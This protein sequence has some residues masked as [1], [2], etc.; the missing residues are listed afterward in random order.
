VDTVLIDPHIIRQTIPPSFF[1]MNVSAFWD[2]A[3]GSVAS[4]R[5]LRQ[6]PITTIRFP[7]GAP[8][9]WYDWQQPTYKGRSHTSPQQIWQYTHSFGGDRVI[10]STNYQGHLPNPPGQSYAVNSPENAAAWVAYN[11]RH[12]IR[13]ALEVGNEEDISLLHKADDRAYLAY[14]NAFNRQARAMHRANPNVQVL[15]PVGTNEWYWWGLD[16][17]GM[18]L[19]GAGN[20]TGTGQVD[21]VSL[22]FYKGTS[23]LD[24]RDVAQYWLSS[25]GPWSAI[26]SAIHAHDTRNLPVSITEWNVGTPALNT[27]FNRTFGHA[28]V[29]ADMIGALA[30]S[31]V[32]QED[33]FDI[34]GAAAWGLLYGVGESRPVDTPTPTYYA[35][36]LWKHMGNQ[37]LDLKQ[38]DDAGSVM[39]AYATRAKNGPIQVLAI[40]KQPAART[41][42]IELQGVS[43]Q[44]QRVSVYSLRGGTSGISSL[45]SVYDGKRT[46]S[47]LRPLPG[48]T[49]LGTARG[50]VISYT[51]P[52]YTAV[53]LNVAGVTKN[54]GIK[55]KAPARTAPP[56][57]PSVKTIGTVSQATLKPGGTEQL[58]ASVRS[59]T[60][61]GTAVVDLELYDAS[62]TKVFQDTQNVDIAANKTYSVHRQYKL[63]DSAHGGTYHYKIG[64]FGPGWT[65]IYTWN[66]SAGGFQVDA[67]LAAA[68]RTVPLSRTSLTAG[69]RHTVRHV[70]TDVHHTAREIWHRLK[71]IIPH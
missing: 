64:V 22:H 3:A 21:G 41:L 16:G 18:F 5:A 43:P 23:W 39:S 19:K 63:P 61:L 66:D 69:L 52:G 33:F 45:D 57:A 9:D 10:F 40:N 56:P 55:W 48:P 35:M 27:P 20:K 12:S 14:I 8:A 31:G 60:D 36:A 46:P 6:T 54:A 71:Q 37:M 58:H 28:I 50:H 49:S 1:G 30:L 15:G 65:P 68:V 53:V 32:K 51:V 62:N 2:A 67:P 13:A 70:L 11:Q 17:L 59:N 34:H 24:S 47:P 7:G 4:A 38:S 26:E 29:T 44:G 42:R 25:K